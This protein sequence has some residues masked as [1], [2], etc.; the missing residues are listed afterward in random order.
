MAYFL[1]PLAE[2]VLTQSKGGA[3]TYFRHNLCRLL[4]ILLHF[5]YYVFEDKFKPAAQLGK[6]I[7]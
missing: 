7:Q 5:G 2:N 3:N 6:V 4:R 1:L